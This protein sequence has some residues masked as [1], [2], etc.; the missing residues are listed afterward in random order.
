M[1]EHPFTPDPVDVYVGAQIR[2]HRKRKGV[3][4]ELLSQALGVSFQQVQ[5][6]ENGT[7][8]VSASMLSRTAHALGIG[9]ER[10]FPS[11]DREGAAETICPTDRMAAMTG[12]IELAEAFIA[13]PT[14]ARSSLVNIAGALSLAFA[15]QAEEDAEADHDDRGA[16]RVA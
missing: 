8:R 6:Y 4:Q 9:V 7:N 12:G 10:L 14:I 11:I 2:A 13:L 15:R 3:S 5:K 16:V 1:S